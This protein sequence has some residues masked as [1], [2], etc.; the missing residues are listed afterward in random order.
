[1]LLV[2]KLVNIY[3][4]IYTCVCV[5]VLSLKNILNQRYQESISYNIKVKKFVALVEGDP[6]APFSLDTTLRCWEGLWKFSLLDTT[7]HLNNFFAL[8][9]NSISNRGNYTS[10]LR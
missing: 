8:A 9:A 3:I 10:P 5:C 4:Y 7:K 1:M 2:S 6:K